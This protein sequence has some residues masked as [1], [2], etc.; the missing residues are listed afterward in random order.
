[1]AAAAGGAAGRRG[2]VPA[3]A[4]ECIQLPSQT[5]EGA[6]TYYVV[7][8]PGGARLRALC[9]Y[10]ASCAARSVLIECWADEKE[11][12]AAAR[13]ALA[14]PH[15]RALRL[16]FGYYSDGLLRAVAGRCRCA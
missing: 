11:A 15:L 8:G 16:N 9:V 10:C 2:G 12:E 14:S 3:Q 4:E 7:D 5:K 1:M 13:A 6:V